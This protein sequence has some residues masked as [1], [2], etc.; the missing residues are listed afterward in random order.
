MI[1]RFYMKSCLSFEE[2]GLDFDPG[3]IVFTGPSGSGKSVLMRSILASVGY[4]EALAEVSEST[5]TWSIDEEET[6]IE[7]EDPNTFRQVKKEKVRYFVNNQSVS[8]KCCSRSPAAT[9]AI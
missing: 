8:K 1:E 9:C 6:G 5:V 7:N 3:L 2:V 4:E